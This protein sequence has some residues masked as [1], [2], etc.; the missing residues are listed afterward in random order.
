MGKR[1]PPPLQDGLSGARGQGVENESLAGLEGGGQ[2][3][4]TMA[5]VPRHMLSNACLACH[6]SPTCSPHTTAFGCNW[7]AEL[8]PGS[9]LQFGLQRLLV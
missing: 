1:P 5:G 9:F 8:S 4:Q 6:A 3:S 7:E 2:A